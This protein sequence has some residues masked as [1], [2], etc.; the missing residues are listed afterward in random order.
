MEPR[1]AIGGYD[2]TTCRYTLRAG[3]QSAHQLRTVLAQVLGVADEALR[4]I[5]PD[6]GGGFGAR[7][8]AYPEFVL[9]L[10]AAQ[11]LGRPVK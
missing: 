7:N 3:C 11:A 5:V 1:A 9:V 4:V 8:I 10:F 2:P 6:V